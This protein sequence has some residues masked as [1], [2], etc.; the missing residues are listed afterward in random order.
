MFA[1]RIGSSNQYGSNGSSARAIFIAVGRFHSPCNS[2]WMSMLSP[3][4]LRIFLERLHAFP[5]VGR[6]CR[7]RRVASAA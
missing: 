3:T 2:T 6:R 1:G 5:E 7:C 4:R